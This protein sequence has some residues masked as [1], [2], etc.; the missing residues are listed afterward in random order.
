MVPLKVPFIQRVISLLKHPNNTKVPGSPCETQ[1]TSLGICQRASP[2]GLPGVGQAHPSLRRLLGKL[3][4]FL[5]LKLHCTA[6]MSIS[7]IFNS[8]VEFAETLG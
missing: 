2:R 3:S 1:H 7:P 6:L 4:K 5:V 8:R